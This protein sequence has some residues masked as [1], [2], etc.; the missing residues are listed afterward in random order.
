MGIN[1]TCFHVGIYT[2]PPYSINS[3]T[4]YRQPRRPAR[5][6]YGESVLGNQEKC[7]CRKGVDR[8]SLQSTNNDNEK[9]RLGEEG[10]A[11]CG[12]AVSCLTLL[13][14]FFL[15]FHLSL[16]HAMYF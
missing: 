8:R 14:S 2:H 10:E 15:P 13:A 11:T 9:Y 12:S 6:K 4:L 16:K 7:L 3:I 1:K 5:G